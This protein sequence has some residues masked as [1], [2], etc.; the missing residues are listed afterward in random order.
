M[1]AI[2]IMCALFREAKL[3]PHILPFVADALILA[4]QGFAHSVWAVSLQQLTFFDWFSDWRSLPGEGFSVS[5]WS[6][7]SICLER[8]LHCAGT[9]VFKEEAE[10]L[11][12][13]ICANIILTWCKRWYR[14][15]YTIGAAWDLKL[16]NSLISPVF[17]LPVYRRVAASWT[18]DVFNLCPTLPDSYALTRKEWFGKELRHSTYNQHMTASSIMQFHFRLFALLDVGFI[19]DP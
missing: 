19:V 4:I 10:S 11:H 14:Y 15:I 17:V 1:H 7:F 5:F 2:N 18:N 3:G 16:Q 9:Y 6:F 13:Q 8:K 12:V